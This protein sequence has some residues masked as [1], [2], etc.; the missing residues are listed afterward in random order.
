ML[1]PGRE[2][3]SV[4][5]TAAVNV[6][7]W[8]WQDLDVGLPKLSILLP[9]LG[10]ELG[11]WHCC[12]LAAGATAESA[13][14]CGSAKLLWF[15]FLD[16]QLWTWLQAVFNCVWGLFRDFELF[17]FR[18]KKKKGKLIT[19]SVTYAFLYHL[20]CVFSDGALHSS[21]VFNETANWLKWKRT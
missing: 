9:S 4:F 6:Q 14:G 15:S 12:G 21:I 13:A 2:G 10:L 3:C 20:L 1:E 18:G 19:A 5:T 11:L 7:Q 16:W 17:I 8:G